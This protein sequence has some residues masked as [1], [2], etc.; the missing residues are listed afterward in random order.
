MIYDVNEQRIQE[1]LR[2]LLQ[3][4]WVL[5]HIE[6]EM[7]GRVAQFALERAIHLAAECVVDVGTTLIDDFMMRD[8]GGYA[9][10]IEILWD[11]E[12]IT[13]EI[14]EALIELVQIRNRL[15]REYHQV[16]LDELRPYQGYPQYLMRFKEQVLVFIHQACHREGDAVVG[17]V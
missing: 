1:Q 12:V 13:Q 11:Q 10:V 15:V 7:K 16:E 8:P 3:C 2:H 6:E 5:E 4:C 17:L 9:D 14:A